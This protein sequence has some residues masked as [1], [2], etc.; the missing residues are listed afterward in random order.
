MKKL[1][2]LPV[3]TYYI[4]DAYLSKNF[5]PFFI[6]GRFRMVSF[7][8]TSFVGVFATFHLGFIVLVIPAFI[9]IFT[10]KA[11]PR[12]IILLY[13]VSALLFYG[14]LIYGLFKGESFSLSYFTSFSFMFGF[15]VVGFFSFSKLVTPL[16]VS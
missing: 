5:A 3:A 12:K 2:L 7:D 1:F 13:F 10:P 4:L 9:F 16:S 11:W 6:I 14:G 15:G 8:W